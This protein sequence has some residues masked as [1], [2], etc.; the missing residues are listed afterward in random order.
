V[1]LPFDKVQSEKGKGNFCLYHG[2]LSVAENE[3]SALWLLENVFSEI[4]IPFVIAGK[5]PSSFLKTQAEKNRN[6]QLV[7]NPSQKEMEE[8]IKN[9]HIHLLPSFNSTGIKIKLL[10]ALFNGRF[11]IT[12]DV[13]LDGTELQSFCYV[14]ENPREYIDKI[15]ELYKLSFSEDELN[16]RK[17]RLNKIYNNEKNAQRVMK[18]L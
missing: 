3:K 16:K 10:N 7:Q 17:E 1:F 11:I 5:N 2:N 6:V 13:S 4:D 9:A 18:W 8:L 14:A 12:N 15:E